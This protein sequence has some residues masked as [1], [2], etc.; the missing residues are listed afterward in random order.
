MI[1]R[2]DIDFSQMFELRNLVDNV[3]NFGQWITVWQREFV[4]SK[5]VVNKHTFFSTSCQPCL[6]QKFEPTKG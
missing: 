3:I 6:P 4:C 2:L 5:R 1:S